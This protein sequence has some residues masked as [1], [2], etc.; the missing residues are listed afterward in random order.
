MKTA[1][2]QRT[3]LITLIIAFVILLALCLLIHIHEYEYSRIAPTCESEGYALYTC[4]CGESYTESVC[5]ALG[6]TYEAT[7]T[8]PG[9]NED[10]YT[11]HVCSRCRDTYR[12]EIVPKH[13]D[14][15]S[16]LSEN[17]FLLPIDYYSRA[18]DHKPEYVM[19]HF[20]SAVVLDP[21][22]PYDMTLTRS[23]YL[24]AYVSTHYTIDR[25]GN[26]YC[27]IPEALVAYHAGKGT[28]R[29]DGKYTDSMNDYAIGI[30]LMG[31]GT[32]KEMSIYMTAAN[33]N[34][35]D[36]AH[37]GFTDAQYASLKA[38]VQ[39]IC[40]RNDIPMDRDHVIG[41]EDYSPKK[42]DPGDLFDWDRLLS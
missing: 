13:A 26:I 21:K 22:N 34:K 20:M 11:E 18:R 3:I 12:D 24:D 19:I 10:G 41:H 17:D 31:I 4:R 8:P 39:D 14:V 9:L 2:P 42:V 23:T 28:W 25:E 33:Y 1:N 36:P 7:V 38:L 5:P 6:H 32:Q 37:L 27:Y 29:D 35:L 15:V 40:D 16:D 30:E